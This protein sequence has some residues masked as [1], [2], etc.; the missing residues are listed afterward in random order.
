MKKNPQVFLEHILESI[1]WIEQE[2]GD[3]TEDQ[4][5]QNVPSQDAVIR[6][7]EIIGEAIKNLPDDFK[8]THP[9]VEWNKP[10]AMR[11][12]LIHNYFGVDLNIVWDTVT[13]LLPEFKKQIKNLLN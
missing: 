1:G 12:I 8:K 4:F 6:R 5:K 11:N 13:Q 3:L 7:L 9:E 10:M 2:I